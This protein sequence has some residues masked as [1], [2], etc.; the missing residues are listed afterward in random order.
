MFF[1]K[2]FPLPASVAMEF[3]RA[4]QSFLKLCATAGRKFMEYTENKAIRGQERVPKGCLAPVNRNP[5]ISLQG[6]YSLLGLSIYSAGD[7]S[8]H[9]RSARW[10]PVEEFCRFR[11]FVWDYLMPMISGCPRIPGVPTQKYSTSKEDELF[12]A[13][14]HGFVK[15]EDDKPILLFDLNGTVVRRGK[16]K[17]SVKLRPGL[18]QLL[19]LK[20]RG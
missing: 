6:S 20:V 4:F 13:S 11:R 9:F 2:G 19:R 17:K 7:S 5:S 14:Q 18:D 12:S 8:K 10:G 16:S 15:M 3:K 1:E